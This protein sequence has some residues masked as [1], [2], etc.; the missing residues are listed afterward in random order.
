MS[1]HVHLLVRETSESLA[2]VI[3]RIGVS[4]AQYYNKKYQHFGHL[5]Q[6][7][8]K[9]EPVN[10]NAYFFTLLRYIRQNPIA[11]GICKKVGSYQWSS[12]AEYEMAENGVQTICST[13]SVLA[14]MPLDELRELVSD[15]LPKT[16]AILDFDSGSAL[17][18]DEEV[19]EFFFTSY[20]LEHPMD[21]HI[22]S[23]KRKN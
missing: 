21:L 3:K 5:Y 23:R 22:Y 17:K 7:R 16:E 2:E 6:D 20:G 4:Y 19:T 1:N 10:D 14:R 15:L 13:K 18:T 12:W 11:A 9:S 8:F